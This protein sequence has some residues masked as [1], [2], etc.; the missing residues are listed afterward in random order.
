MSIDSLLILE[1]VSHL[2]KGECYPCKHRKRVT[3]PSIHVLS[4][5]LYIYVSS[6]SAGQD[7]YQVEQRRIWGGNI[8]SALVIRAVVSE[9][10]TRKPTICW[11]W[12]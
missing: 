5:D 3:P 6:L 4:S 1:F 11:L 12:R 10:E 8:K 9:A 2:G 7:L